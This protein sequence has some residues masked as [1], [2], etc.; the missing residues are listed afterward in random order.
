MDGP[1]ELEPRPTGAA[2]WMGWRLRLL[3]AAVLAGCVALI[4]LALWVSAQPQLQIRWQHGPGGSITPVDR[5]ISSARL[6]AIEADGRR[7]VL[8]DQPALLQASSRWTP[9]DEPRRAV[10][11]WHRTL[12]AAL[13]APGA[14][15]V[16]DDGRQVPVV[17]DTGSRWPPPT[18]WL[19]AA[20]ALAV[21][22]TG[23]VVVLATPDARTALYA[24]MAVCQG[25]NLLAIAI[26]QALQWGFPPVW[27]VLD[28]PL[29]SSFDLLTAAAM[30]QLTCLHPRRLSDAG[31]LSSL[32][33][34]TA[35]LMSM[36]AIVSAA[37]NQGPLPGGWWWV[38]CSV[39]L[40]GL[41]AI[42]L[43]TWS[44][45]TEAHPLATLLRRVGL[46]MLGGWVLLTVG[47]A[48]GHRV[49]GGH[50]PWLDH[51][52]LVWTVFLV[53][54]LL[55]AP[56]IARAPAAL[57]EFALVAGVS[58]FAAALDLLLVALFSFGRV[59]SLTIT[60]FLSLGLY[61]G[62]RHWLLGR[63]LGQR[64]LST[65]RLF[66]L[67]LRSARE[68]ETHPERGPTAMLALL[69][70]VFEPIE[71][72]TLPGSRGT[73]ARVVEDGSTLWLPMPAALSAPNEP[74]PTLV[75]R[76]AQRGRRLFTA[77]DARLADSVAEQLRRAAAFGDAVE[78]GRNEERL[79]LAQDLHDDIGARLLTLMYQAPTPEVEDYVRHTLQDLKTLT[80]G[81]AASTHLLSH[82]AAEWKS[83]L[84]HRLEPARIQLTWQVEHDQDV[85]LSV[86][87]WS[88]LTRVLRELVS[89]V[90]AH[91]RARRLEVTLRLTAGNLELGVADDGVGREPGVW[92]HGLGLGGVRKRV[93]QLGGDVEWQEL[94]PVGIRCLVRIPHFTGAGPTD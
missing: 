88:A 56:F 1:A 80:R 85:V 4:S 51:M 2:R 15:W 34:T 22:V 69:R 19:L 76:F 3:V 28:A 83:D 41:A 78:Q 81:L 57:R 50:T 27:S 70:D 54:L 5:S 52:P 67:L 64:Q 14:A 55:I 16:F 39:A 89:N 43:L 48:L 93:R 23:L 25:G 42:W 87:Q 35:V 46:L 61:A 33:W 63:L 30:V 37:V 38:Q 12:H 79:R 72:G 31:W 59:T 66:E 47:T 18:F 32:A 90:I 21:Y 17:A 77:A 53:G 62:A 84:T 73:A 10:Q 58:T 36:A 71:S 40:M 65:A 82:A 6:V 60:L 49:T 8:P 7:L 24:L 11:V 29:R 92:S 74:A 75:L 94:Q 91:A 20:A 44:R 26:E 9:S 13:N 45:R 68:I 86:V